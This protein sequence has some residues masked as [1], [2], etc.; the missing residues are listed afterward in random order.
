MQMTNEGFSECLGFWSALRRHA[1]G[2]HPGYADLAD[3]LFALDTGWAIDPPVYVYQESRWRP[4]YHIV[5]RRDGR[6]VLLSLP[7]S[8]ALRQ[9][10][11]ERGVPLELRPGGARVKQPA[12]ARRA[13]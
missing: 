11:E 13:G 1:E 8:E 3:L 2:L 5:L 10:L 6:Q 7:E 9:F 12:R 4:Y